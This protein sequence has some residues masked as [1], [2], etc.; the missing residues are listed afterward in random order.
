MGELTGTPLEKSLEALKKQ[1]VLLDQ[2][3]AR[4][5]ALAQ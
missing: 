1:C 5:Q 4:R 3:V 2:Q